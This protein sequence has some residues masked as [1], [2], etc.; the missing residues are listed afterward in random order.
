MNTNALDGRKLE[1]PD[2]SYQTIFRPLL[3]RLPCEMAR[4]FTLHAMGTISKLPGGSLLIR[5]LGHMESYP[6]LN[7]SLSG[8]SLRYPVGI[9]GTLDVHGLAPRALAQFGLGFMEIG[10]ITLEPIRSIRPIQRDVKREA[11][12]YPDRY[13]NDGVEATLQRLMNGKNYRLPLMIRTHH[14]P[15]SSPAV[16]AAQQRELLT[17]LVPFASGLYLDVFDPSWTSEETLD[18]FRDVILAVRTQ[19]PELPVFFYLPLECNHSLLR[20]L[21]TQLDFTM[22]QGLV[23]GEA[24]LT[25][26]GYEVG[27]AGKLASLELISLIQEFSLFKGSIIATAGIH[28]P[29]DAIEL[30]QAGADYVQLHSGLVYSG[31]GLP[32]RI[33][34]AIIHERI[35][36]AEAPGLPEL[37]SFWKSW[38]W[39]YFLGLAMILGGILA[40][41]IAASTVVLPYDTQFLGI[42][43]DQINSFNDKLLPF[44]SH[45]R[46]TLAGTMISIGVIYAQLARYGLSKGQHWSKTALAVSGIVGFISFFLFLGYGYFDPLHGL[47]AVLLIPLFLLSMRTPAN[48]PSWEPPNLRNSREWVLAQWGQLMFVVLGF[49]LAVGGATISFIGITHVFVPTDLT[50]LGMTSHQLD[51]HNSHFLPL[52]AHDRAGFGGALLSNA[53]AILT[54]ALWGVNQGERWLWWTFLLGGMPGFVAGLGVHAA[55]N[56][57]DFVHLLPA[58]FAFA[59]YV[60]GLIFL[61]PYLMGSGKKANAA[62]SKANLKVGG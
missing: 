52:I 62:E 59:L 61:Y 25:K 18:C 38:G 35:Q 2:W 24:M 32:K 9:S 33:N 39:M 20:Q 27:R 36:A 40:W 11:I 17:K 7:S 19:Y 12:L 31:P 47:V 43:P 45:D 16:A 54:T 6:I 29:V 58:Y 21:L 46:I 8:V 53:L 30:I 23:L 14:T 28:E 55:I 15:G 26:Q 50:F 4:D 22:L 10:P 44:M 51:G 41:I 49:A 34:E 1:M 5:T 37:P 57:T 42:G 56:Y 48:R 60:L 3:F 13:I